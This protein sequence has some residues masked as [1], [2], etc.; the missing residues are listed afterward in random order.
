M[1]HLFYTSVSTGC[2]EKVQLITPT[3]V[4][5][6]DDVKVKCVADG[7]QVPRVVVLGKDCNSKVEKLNVDEQN[8]NC[9]QVN[10]MVKNVNTSCTFRCFICKSRDQKTVT[11]VG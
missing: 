2:E 8:V 5:A 7:I 11:V 10:F 3:S 1:K 4:V 6:G 9:G